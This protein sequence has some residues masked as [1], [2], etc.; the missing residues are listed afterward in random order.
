MLTYC[1]RAHGYRMRYFIIL[2]NL[3]QKVKKKLIM[4]DVASQSIRPPVLLSVWSN[5]N[6]HTHKMNNNHK[7]F[8]PPPHTHTHHTP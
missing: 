8:P 7:I 4:R 3:A 2:N 1:V 6:P 5:N